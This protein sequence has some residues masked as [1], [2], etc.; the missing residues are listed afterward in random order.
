MTKRRNE[1]NKNSD[2]RHFDK[3]LRG[4]KKKVSKKDLELLEF[5]ISM[6]NVTLRKR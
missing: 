4:A 6:A 2:R 3:Q 1:K 5:G